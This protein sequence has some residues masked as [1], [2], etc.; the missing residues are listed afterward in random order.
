MRK[1]FLKSYY[2]TLFLPLL[3][4][5]FLGTNTHAV[6]Q[7]IEPLP[8]A[9][10]PEAAPDLTEK[11]TPKFFWGAK[12]NLDFRTR[13][14][15]D[16]QDN[17]QDGDFRST[18]KVSAAGL[19]VFDP[20]ATGS[21][22]ELF[23]EVGIEHQITHEKDESKTSDETDLELKQGS[24]NWKSFLHPS[25]RLQVGRQKFK[26]FREW[27]YDENL[28]AVRLYYVEGPL[29]LQ[30]SLSTNLIDPED[31]E[32]EINNIILFGIYDI[33]KKD[34]IAA[35]I[36]NRQG[37]FDE[38]D[39]DFNL[40]SVGVSL[41]G[42]SIKNQKYWL[43][44][45]IVTG[46]EKAKDVQGYGFDLGWTSRFKYRFKPAITIGY[47]FGSG[48]HTP[49]NNKDKAFRQ[50]GLQDNSTKFRGKSKVKLYGELFEPELSN[51]MIGTIGIGIRPIKN[52]SIDLV[53][54]HYRQVW[55]LQERK[56]D[57]RDVG[58]KEDPNGESRDLGDE[59][60]IIFGWKVSDKIKIEALAAYFL[61]GTA[62]PDTDNA[63]L[64]KVKARYSF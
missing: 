50:T 55:A 17:D 52:G 13:N 43:D 14:N 38:D 64:A 26:D 56:N 25:L 5:I 2:T 35:Y 12:L 63:F 7:E 60:D 29:E 61:P 44:A 36:V 57:L 39:P 27:I 1:I 42:K 10:D 28:D 47:A 4:I 20:S 62:F 54:H 41:K 6:E 53:Y 11:I 16:L 8:T 34:K 48:D 31:V 49:D 51:L 45:A 3:L 40:T 21:R 30:L 32:D 59:V 9:I 18:G 37:Q 24:F 58:I 15:R 33:W 46:D 22:L 19:Y 23:G